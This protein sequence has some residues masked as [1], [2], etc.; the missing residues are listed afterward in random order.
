MNVVPADYHDDIHPWKN[1]AAKEGGALYEGKTSIAWFKLIDGERFMGCVGLLK[2]GSR[3]NVRVRGWFTPV[4]ARGQGHGATLLIF[5]VEEARAR[6][7]RTIECR[8]R[9]FELCYRV[10]PDFWRHT[11]RGPWYDGAIQLMGD[12]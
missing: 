2:A 9:H 1:A 11:G 7:Y 5:A 4:H 6:G 10:M 12:L 8:T 3:G